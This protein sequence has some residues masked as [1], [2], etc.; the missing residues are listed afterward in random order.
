MR[1]KILLT[2][3]GGQIGWEL[4]RALPNLGEVVPIGRAEMDLTDAAVIRRTLRALEP[5]VIVNAAGY[6]AVD[7][8]ESEPDLAHAVNAVAPGI[9]AEE[10][11]R[12][13]AVIVCYSTDYI[14]DG[15][16]GAPYR[17]NDEPNPVNVYGRTKLAG[18]QAVARSGAAHLILRTSW[19]YSTRRRNFLLT[20]L[21]LAAEQA[22]LR[23][24]NDQHG[25][26]SWSRLIARGTEQILSSALQRTGRGWSLGGG[27]GI[28]HLACRGVTSWYDL[29]RHILQ[30]A[31]VDPMPT[32]TPIT[33][34]QYPTAA[35]R[36]AYSALDCEQ[37]HKRF[38]V[39]LGSWQPAVVA[40][41]R[42]Q[43]PP[44]AA[45]APGQGEG[46]K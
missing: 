28:H 9:L 23:V 6:T 41:L 15:T 22:E 42:D 36:P 37:T 31:A 33:T 40:A 35:R 32:I 13:G 44:V 25:C 45:A 18:E 10:A 19:V 16:K 38:G 3:P 24:V 34:E 11:A 2:G 30:S 17:P 20:I 7:Q 21:R 5:A 4:G 12:L 29:A 26:P 46:E 1:M 27:E 14:F 8:A 43:A 39:D